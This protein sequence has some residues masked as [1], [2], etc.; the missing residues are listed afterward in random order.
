MKLKFDRR[1]NLS[2]L[3]VS[4]ATPPLFE[5]SGYVPVWNNHI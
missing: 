5:S 4:A 3:L 1:V 2:E